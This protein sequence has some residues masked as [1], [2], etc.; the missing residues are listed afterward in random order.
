M[1]RR[2]LS[3]QEFVLF[4]AR[5]TVIP[6]GHS[7][8]S[9]RLKIKNNFHEAIGRWGSTRIDDK[10]KEKTDRAFLLVGGVDWGNG[11]LF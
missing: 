1:I 8:D 11:D 10:K 7:P 4:G 2:N 6:Y 5:P 3:L 9:R